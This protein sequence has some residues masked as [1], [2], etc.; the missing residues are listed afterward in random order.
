MQARLA[1]EHGRMVL[2]MSSL[3]EHDWAREYAVRPGAHVVSS[4]DEIMECLQSLEVGSALL[5]WS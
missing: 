5:S 4:I 1:L 2:L 3:L